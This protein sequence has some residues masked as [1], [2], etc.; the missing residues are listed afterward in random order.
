M[1][2]YGNVILNMG[3]ASSGR[4]GFRISDV[5]ITMEEKPEEPGCADICPPRVL[6]HFE[7]KKSECV[8]DPVSPTGFYQTGVIEF[9]DVKKGKKAYEYLLAFQKLMSDC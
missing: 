4:C 8:Y 9:L 1:D 7:C 3:S 2:D 6:I 5:K